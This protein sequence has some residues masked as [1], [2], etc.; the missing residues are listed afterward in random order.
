M[1]KRVKPYIA[2]TTPAFGTLQDLMEVCKYE[3]PCFERY[4]IP[5]DDGLDSC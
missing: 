4:F 3:L 1:P 2:D 5:Y